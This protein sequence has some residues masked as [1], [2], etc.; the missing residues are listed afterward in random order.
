[1]MM[2]LTK[3]Y[4]RSDSG[5]NEEKSSYEFSYITLNWCA[6]K[7]VANGTKSNF[8]H[9]RIFF[10]KYHDE[11]ERS[12]LDLKRF[13]IS[14]WSICFHKAIGLYREKLEFNYQ[15]DITDFGPT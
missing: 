12:Y 3:S 15:L 9:S 6:T 7:W 5:E 14:N 11:R 1:M 10:Y 2:T 8:H 13:T 4:G